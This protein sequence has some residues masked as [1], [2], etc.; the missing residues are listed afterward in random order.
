MS[1]ASKEKGLC[2]QKLMHMTAPISVWWLLVSYAGHQNR[3]AG[4]TL[5]R[6]FKHLLS[7]LYKYD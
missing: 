6:K 7:S 5:P 1:K 4:Q 2:Q 3:A